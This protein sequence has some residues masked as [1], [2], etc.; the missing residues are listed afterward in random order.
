MEKLHLTDGYRIK[1][2]KPLQAIQGLDNDPSARVIVMKRIQKKRIV[3]PVVKVTKHTMIKK[4]SSFVICH[5][6]I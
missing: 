6:E 4:S 2:F 5:A 1:G 3:S